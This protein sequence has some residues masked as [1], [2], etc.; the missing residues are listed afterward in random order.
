MPSFTQRNGHL[1]VFDYIDL[2]SKRID[3]IKE[4][5]GWM[6]YM[7][8]DLK[9]A[10]R[11]T[12]T[13]SLVRPAENDGEAV[14][15]ARIVLGNESAVVNWMDQNERAAFLREATD[16]RSLSYADAARKMNG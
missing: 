11:N 2:N 7:F 13:F 14:Q 4:R 1:D 12:G 9:E 3:K 5:A 6:A 16:C 8:S 10:D 15:Y